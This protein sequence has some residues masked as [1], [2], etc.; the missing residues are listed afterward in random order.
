[1]PVTNLTQFH[2]ATDGA[3]I[4]V[5]YAHKFID[6][7]TQKEF[8]AVGWS[9]CSPLDRFN[10]EYGKKVAMY[11]AFSFMQLLAY[12]PKPVFLPSH[13]VDPFRKFVIRAHKYFKVAFPDNLTFETKYKGG[14]K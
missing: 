6:S 2:R 13:M 7:R 10:K 5:M 11:R 4:G 8:V 14:R 1:M 9:S 12:L 3:P